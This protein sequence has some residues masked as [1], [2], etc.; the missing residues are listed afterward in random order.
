MSS[1]VETSLNISEQI[2]PIGLVRLPTLSLLPSRCNRPCR[3]LPLP[4]IPLAMTSGSEVI[5]PVQV[6]EKI[7]PPF[8]VGQKLF[9]QLSGFEL[10]V[11][12][13]EAGEVI[14]CTL[15][16]VFARG[17]APHQKRPIARL[18]E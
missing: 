8:A 6:R 9:I 18:R 11:Q 10:V 2:T 7:V 12:F 13:I 1:G 4:S 5:A 17:A 16:C 14:E 3:F 15:G